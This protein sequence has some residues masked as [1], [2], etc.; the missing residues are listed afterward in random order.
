MLQPGQTAPAFVLPDADMHNV[1]L[2]A[3]K[4]RKHVVLYFY[5]RDGTPGCILEASN[6]SDHEDQFVK[7]DCVILGVS[8]DDC[9]SHAEFRDKH[10]LSIGLLSDPEGEV[11]RSYG[12]LQEK[13]TEGVRRECLVRSTFV[14]DK[15]GV[16][17]HAHYGV[18]PRGHA[19]EIYDVVRRLKS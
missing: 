16:I 9:L 11:C 6:F 8:R 7:H 12:V 2:S 15:R 14:I 18:A 5:P 13:E 17:R 1:S 19:S 4:G 10:G 3:F